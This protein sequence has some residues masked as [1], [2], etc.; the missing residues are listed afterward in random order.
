MLKHILPPLVDRNLQ[1]ETIVVN[2]SFAHII[3]QRFLARVDDCIP[4]ITPSHSLKEKTLRCG[5]RNSFRAFTVV[6]L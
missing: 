4:T 3:I 5:F 6:I 1:A 2:N